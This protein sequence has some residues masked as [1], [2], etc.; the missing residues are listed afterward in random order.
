MYIIIDTSSM[1]FAMESR[2]SAIDSVMLRYPAMDILVSK[3]LISELVG[4][5]T[6]K[7]KRGAIARSCLAILKLKNVKVDNNKGNVDRWI[8]ERAQKD[9]V[10][11]AITNDTELFNKLR[12]KNV[13]VLKLSRNGIL[14]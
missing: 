14:K 9:D 12:S 10:Y 2:K 7:G 13:A 11:C 4:I 1:L 6:S 8:L 5:G 3:G